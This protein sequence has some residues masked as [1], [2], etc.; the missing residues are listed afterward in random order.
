ME[1]SMT[2]KYY[3]LW[4]NLNGQHLSN[5][6]HLTEKAAQAYLRSVIDKSG[7]SLVTYR[8]LM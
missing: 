3:A 2:G 5:G 6:P 1:T 4:V 7:G 8:I